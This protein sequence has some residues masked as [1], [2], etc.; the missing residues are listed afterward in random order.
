MLQ[1]QTGLGTKKPQLPLDQTQVMAS[2]A[3]H[4]VDR[5][6]EGALERIS[7]EAPVHL[8]MP[9][10]RLDGAAAFDHRLQCLG[11]P[12]ALPRHQDTHALQGDTAVALYRQSPSSV[13]SR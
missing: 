6:G 1:R 2:A 7:A 5:V 9:D 13:C 11:D 10:G 4:R 12:S 8:H 3:H